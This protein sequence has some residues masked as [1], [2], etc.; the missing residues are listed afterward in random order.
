METFPVFADINNIAYITFYGFEWSNVIGLGIIILL[1]LSSALVSGSEVAFFSLSPV[2][3]E[4]LKSENTSSSNQTIE[5]LKNPEHLLATILISNNFV[6]VAIVIISTWLTDHMVDFNQSPSWFSFLF[7]IVLVTFLLLLF[8]EIIPKVYA[9]KYARSFALLMARPMYILSR[10]FKP[11][12]FSL[13][14]STSVVNKRLKKRKPEISMDDLSNAIDLAENEIKENK[15]ILEGIVSYGN[16]DASEIMKPRVD[17]VAFDITTPFDVLLG[18]I[19]E[20]NYSRI[21]IYAETFDNVKGILYIKDLLPHYHKKNFHW[22]SLLRPPYFVP[23]SKKINDLLQ[24]FQS[25]KNHMAIVIDEY[26]GTS[27]IVTLEDILEEIVGEISD[28]FD[29]PDLFYKKIDKHNYVFEGKT[30]LNDFFKILKLEDDIFDEVKG[31][32]DT[33][34]GLVL[35]LVGEIPQP[36]G[37]VKYKNFVFK[38]ISSDMRRIKQI[39]VTYHEQVVNE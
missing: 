32:A 23:E 38:V 25:K 2:D 21:P 4:Q 9:A 5:L 13:V 39:K 30:L 22:Q 35:E 10:I 8:G 19:K 7:K 12:S 29:E 36:G 18:K 33:L 20:H 26:G 1:L 17:V 31:D 16:T 14:K 37:T 6:N 27:G 11:L 24:D 3:V 34:A 28:E 15:K